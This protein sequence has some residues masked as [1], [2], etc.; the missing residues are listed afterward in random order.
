M[1]KNTKIALTAVLLALV[2]DMWRN[3]VWVGKVVSTCKKPFAGN[4][5]E[6]KN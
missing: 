5:N 3:W 1:N 6:D 2:V 4:P